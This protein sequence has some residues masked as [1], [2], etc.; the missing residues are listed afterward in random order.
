VST[1]DAR[2]HALDAAEVAAALGSDAERGLAPEEA[3]RRLAQEG[4]NELRAEEGRSLLA[5]AAGQFR[6]LVVWLLIGA[7]LVSILLGERL[8]G[9]AILAIVLLN[10][11]IGF[12]QEH[13]AEN[14]V[15]A[16]ARMSAPR[17]R[18]VRG[19][20]SQLVQA[21]DVVRGDLLV[22]EG[23]DVVA[24]DARLVDAALLRVNEAPLTGESEP[25]DKATAALPAATPLADRRNQVFLA[26]SV[27][28]GTA[29]ALVVATGMQTEVGRIAKLLEHAREEQTPL[30][31][32]LEVVGRQ[33]L[34][35]CLAVVAVVS[36]LGALRGTPPFEL[37]IGAVSLAVAAVPEGLPAVVTIAL[38]LGVERMARRQALVRSL[39]AVE[40]LGSTQVIC[41]DKTGTLT[42]GQMTVRRLLTADALLRVTGEGYGADGAIF[43]PEEEDGAR[44]AH[45][46]LWAAAACNEAEIVREGD[47]YRGAGDTTEVALLVAAAKAGVA[48]EEIEREEPRAQVVPFDSDRKR[49]AVV[50]R[51]GGERV[52]YVKGAPEV[53]LARCTHVRTGTGVAPLDR[54][55]HARLVQGMGQL[56][57]EALRV[58]ALAERT[59]PADAA[60]GEDVESELTLLGFAGL[61]DPPRAEARD[62][63]A[64]CQRAG[65]RTVMIT[66]DHPATARAIAA[67]LGILGAE[68]EVLAGPELE[69][70][71]P[72]ALR[73]RAPRIAVYARVTAEQKLGIVR[74]WKA[75]GAI[76]AMTGDGVNDA[77]ALREASIG[78]AMGTTGTEVAKQASDIVIADDDF[79]SIVAA[80]EEGRGI[81]DNVSKTLAYLLAGN[82]GELGL[83]LL[84]GLAGFPVP[85]LPVQLLWINLVTDGLPALALAT[86]PIEPG[87]M[88]R[89]PR[90]AT[91]QLADAA[92]L[93][94]LLLAGTLTAVVSLGAYSFELS[95]GGDVEAARNAAFSTLVFAELLRAFGARSANRLV[96]EVGVFTNLRLFA[97]VAASFGLQLA[98][99][100][101]PLLERL[102]QT[103]PLSAA[104]CVGLI[105][106][107]S[108]PLLGLELRKLLL[109]RRAPDLA[110]A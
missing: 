29:R 13:R 30:Q 7:A 17:A 46:L 31:R 93:R 5:M 19:G 21:R 26:T 89:P 69:Q 42:V 50:R 77:P 45:R 67:E 109:R 92:T 22:L 81:F 65:I 61:Q 70:L 56:A 96:Y 58:L 84:A 43:G 12:V 27:S 102:F 36:G 71:S 97:V 91:A 106:L 64:R 34:W 85:L 68:D 2:W 101:T 28:N 1:P 44:D 88:R 80:V 6:S 18:V 66:G 35:A 49:M 8:D 87:V 59:L 37:F 62:A 38:A 94:S 82:L 98:I 40:T 99:H 41:T 39:P 24:A 75:R 33:L 16:L 52:A 79:A 53:V 48:R 73:E 3:A 15:R 10:G 90:P 60:P 110:A 23:G 103:E 72:D 104:Q 55:T 47:V 51:R 32:R 83:M 57:A 86:E 25:V 78:V 11:L 95:R 100:H 107:G 4:P 14:A 9:G 108:V 63:V 74:A 105:A 54:E 76:V 20:H